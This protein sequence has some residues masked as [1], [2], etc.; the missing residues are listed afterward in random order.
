MHCHCIRPGGNANTFAIDLNNDLA[1]DFSFSI[2]STNTSGGYTYA[3]VNG[4]PR[5]NV[6]HYH[7]A[8]PAILLMRN[9]GEQR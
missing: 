6:L 5:K 4:G 8:C 1:N 7:S 3:A 2:F 9:T